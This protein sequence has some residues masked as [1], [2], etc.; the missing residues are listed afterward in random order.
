MGLAFLNG[1]Y[2]L[3]DVRNDP[4]FGALLKKIGLPAAYIP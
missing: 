2:F 4:R 3:E 1:A